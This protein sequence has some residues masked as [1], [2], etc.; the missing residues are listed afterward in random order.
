MKSEL[1]FFRNEIVS[2]RFFFLG[3]GGEEGEF[4]FGKIGK[5]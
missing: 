4:S 2:L 1:S 5:I 3:G